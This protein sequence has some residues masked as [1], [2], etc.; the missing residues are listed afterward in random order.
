MLMYDDHVWWSCMI[1]MYDDHVWWSYMIIVYDDHVWWSYMMIIYDDHIWWWW[2]Y[3]MITY[4]YIYDDHL[5]W[6]YIIYV[7]MICWGKFQKTQVVPKLFWDLWDMFWHHDWCLRNHLDLLTINLVGRQAAPRC[8]KYHAFNHAFKRV[9]KMRSTY[10]QD[11]C[12]HVLNVFSQQF[13]NMFSKPYS[14]SSS[15]STMFSIHM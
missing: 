8:P 6:S 7:M 13:A 10:V 3:M 12:E 4:I 11:T 15:A 5:W 2:S 9:F 14:V 1:I